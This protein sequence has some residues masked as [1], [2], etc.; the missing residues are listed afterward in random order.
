MD[1]CWILGFAAR[2][3]GAS[4]RSGA[5][6]ATH[7]AIAPRN[8]INLKSVGKGYGSHTVLDDVTLG[9]NEGERVGIVGENGA[10]KS[11]LVRLIAGHE[12]PD[13][14]VVTRTAGVASVL[15][16]QRDE[17]NPEETVR[18]ALVGTRADHE[19]A[20]DAAFRNVLEGLLG[21][22][23]VA[24]FT[25]GMQTPIGT[26]SGGER[27]RIMLARAL[28]GSPALLL[29]DE[30][31]NHLDVE[32]ISWLA[33]FLA[34]RRGT[35]LVITHDRWFLDAVCDRTWEVVDAGVHQYDGGYSAYVLARAE[36]DRQACARED[37][38]RQLVRKELAWLRRGPPGPD[39]QAEVP[40]RGRQ[41]PDCRRAPRPQH[42][43]AAALRHRAAR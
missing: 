25:D 24:V 1:G 35:L 10:G 4:G 11:T 23:D 32:G 38:R 14:G 43:G 6:S 15:V 21:G 5:R 18:D 22:V 13:A 40:Y 7:E 28:L 19:W 20:A 26:L 41:H 3:L 2:A 34:A 8:L 29:L 37:R 17:L 12:D 30:P 39:L 31:T 9:L 42:G 27:R 33:G 16:S 36:R